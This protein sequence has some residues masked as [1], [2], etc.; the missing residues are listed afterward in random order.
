MPLPAILQSCGRRV[1]PTTTMVAGAPACFPTLWPLWRLEQ[2]C[3]ARMC[4]GPSDW[5]LRVIRQPVVLAEYL[6]YLSLLLPPL[7]WFWVPA[8]V[9]KRQ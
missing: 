1:C 7:S 3:A 4:R 2:H 9:P 5:S 6:L 8:A